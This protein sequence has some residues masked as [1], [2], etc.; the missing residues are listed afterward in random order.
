[1]IGVKEAA[2][3]DAETTAGQA[4]KMIDGIK[5]VTPKPPAK[6]IPTQAS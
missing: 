1:V 6:L 5:K 3:I 2:G 4:Q